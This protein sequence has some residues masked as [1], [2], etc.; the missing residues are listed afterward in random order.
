MHFCF[1][2]GNTLGCDKI[3]VRKQT[4]SSQTRATPFADL[5]LVTEGLR[6]PP[7]AGFLHPEGG[8]EK[9]R[10]VERLSDFLEKDP[11]ESKV[12]AH[13]N[14]TTKT[15]TDCNKIV[16]ISSEPV[17]IHT[18]TDFLIGLILGHL[19]NSPATTIQRWWRSFKPRPVNRSSMIASEESSRTPMTADDTSTNTPAI[20][21]PTATPSI[22]MADPAQIKNKGD[23][24]LR[25]QPCCILM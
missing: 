9:G 15:R 4:T 25:V 2:R 7:S 10:P 18:Y 13:V 8:L 19:Q 16:R 20:I 12:L 24:S 23:P 17:Q 11:A 22:D 6:V 3:S 14:K 21:T 1:K 5:Q